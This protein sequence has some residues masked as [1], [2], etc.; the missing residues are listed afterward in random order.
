MP[1]TDDERRRGG[2]LVDAGGCLV[3]FLKKEKILK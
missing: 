1:S 3:F 2:E